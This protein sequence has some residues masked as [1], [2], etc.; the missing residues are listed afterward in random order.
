MEPLVL[1]L[2]LLLGLGLGAWLGHTYS[3]KLSRV[4]LEAERAALT[5]EFKVIANDILEDK[6]KRF[7]AQNQLNLE[8]MLTPLQQQI[9]EF[10][11]KVEEVY[12]QEGKDRSALAEQVRQLMALNQQV[13]EEAR[14]SPRPSRDQ[15]RPK[16]TGASWCSSVCWRLRAFARAKSMWFKR[17][18]PRATAGAFSQ[19]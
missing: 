13:S 17:A 5:N 10:K 16:A 9:R 19:M 1:T 8:Q 6:S 12:V 2:V 7:T 15:T 4:Q 3:Q 14:A 11:G 18:T